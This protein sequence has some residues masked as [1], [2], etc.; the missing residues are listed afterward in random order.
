MVLDE[1]AARAGVRLALVASLQYLPPRQRAVLILRDVLAWPAA[2][3]AEMLRH[4]ATVVDLGRALDYYDR[5]DHAATL[6]TSSDLGGFSHVQ[7]ALLTSILR[8]ADGGRPGADRA[9]LSVAAWAAERL[10]ETAPAG[11]SP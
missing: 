6:V 3:V 10:R 2:D 9:L 1:L 7:L 4:A 11:A 5:F 8:L